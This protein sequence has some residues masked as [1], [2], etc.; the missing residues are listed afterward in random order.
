MA[1]EM[2][3]VQGNMPEDIFA[4]MVHRRLTNQAKGF[5]AREHNEIHLLADMKLDNAIT[6]I[7]EGLWRVANAVQG[8]R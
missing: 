7:D 5:R 1:S 3:T 2:R 8:Q 4:D 6:E